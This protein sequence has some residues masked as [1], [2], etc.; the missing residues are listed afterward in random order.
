VIRDGHLPFLSKVT[1]WISCDLSW[2]S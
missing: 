2:R 1:H